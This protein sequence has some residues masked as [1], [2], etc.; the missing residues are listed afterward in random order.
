MNPLVITPTFTPRDSVTFKI[1]LSEIERL[2]LISPSQEIE[3]CI[4]IANGDEHAVSELVQANLRFAISVAKKYQGLGLPLSDLVA[5]ANIG[6]IKAARRFDHTRGFKFISYAVW[7]IRQSILEA[8]S[9]KGRNIRIPGNQIA[10]MR[11]VKTATEQLEQQ[12][13]RHPTAHEIATHLDVTVEAVRRTQAIDQK[14]SS[15]DKQVNDESPG[16]A[17]L[18]EFLSNVDVPSPTASLE[19]EDLLKEIAGALNALPVR[20]ADVLS[21]TFGLNHGQPLTFEEVG[22]RMNLSKE[23]VRQLQQR[24]LQTLRTEVPLASLRVY[25]N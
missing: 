10:M 13:E 19:R 3:L 6:L 9:T 7:W 12:L 1:Y 8:V 16:G 23:R 17:T 21:W 14:V 4:R 11:K 2:P 5:E 22:T 20:Q 25:L 15:L 18:I 24:A